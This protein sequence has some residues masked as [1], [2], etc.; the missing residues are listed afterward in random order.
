M[1]SGSGEPYAAFNFIVE[2]DGVAVAAFSEVSGLEFEIEPIEY[3]NGNEP[4]ASVRKIPGLR[5]YANITLKRGVSG[6]DDFWAWILQALQGHV[7]KRDGV[8]VLLNED[9]EPALRWVFRSGWPC[10]YSGPDFNAK[11]NEIA[12]ESVEICHEGL[13]LSD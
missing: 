5:K 6:S 7:E 11:A 12:M 3:R 4:Y 2:L 8:I 13:V 9:R 10:K 1:P